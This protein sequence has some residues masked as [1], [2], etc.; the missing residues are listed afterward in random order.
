MLRKD[1]PCLF[2]ALFL[3]L[4]IQLSAQNAANTT[5]GQMPPGHGIKC[6]KS[7]GSPCGDPEVS[8]LKQDITDAKTTYGDSK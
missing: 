1:H 7:D 6:Q 4:A 2:T 3:S 8:D 5:A